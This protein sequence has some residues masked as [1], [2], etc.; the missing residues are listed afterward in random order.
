MGWNGKALIAIIPPTAKLRINWL[1]LTNT[2]QIY[3]YYQEQA[4]QTFVDLRNGGYAFCDFII[5]LIF[6]FSNTDLVTQV[7]HLM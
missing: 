3:S 4:S 2:L 7:G 5:I 1:I 6:A